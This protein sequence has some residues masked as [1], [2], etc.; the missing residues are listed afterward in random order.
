[1]TQ[2]T[3]VWT[4]TKSNSRAVNSHLSHFSTFSPFD[5]LIY[6]S[7]CASCRQRISQSSQYRT[8]T[9]HTRT[10]RERKASTTNL[11]YINNSVDSTP[12]SRILHR[13]FALC[14]RVIHPSQERHRL[15][16]HSWRIS[17]TGNKTKRALMQCKQ[18][19]QEK[20]ERAECRKPTDCLLPLCNCV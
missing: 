5:G 11:T 12:R 2:H 20:N 10:G 4:F 14:R 18:L 7:V 8:A 13:T 6:L 1:M 9:A 3:H 19:K 15:L 16:S 17:K